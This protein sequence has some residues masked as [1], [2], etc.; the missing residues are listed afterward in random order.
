M[1][2][3]SQTIMSNKSSNGSVPVHHDNSFSSQIPSKNEE[4][5]VD[6]D[7]VSFVNLVIENADSSL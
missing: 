7:E 1:L 6:S 2:V 5:A 3:K 4:T